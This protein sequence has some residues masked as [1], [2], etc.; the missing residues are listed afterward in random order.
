[1]L[2]DNGEVLYT[3]HRFLSPG[4]SYQ[5]SLKIVGGHTL[6][7]PGLK[8]I[9]SPGSKDHKVVVGFSTGVKDDL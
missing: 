8:I 6:F 7:E 4:C 9:F 5:L 2:E 3:T 1:M